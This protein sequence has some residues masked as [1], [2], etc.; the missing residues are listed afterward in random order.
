MVYFAASCNCS[1]IWNDKLMLIELCMFV[2]KPSITNLLKWRE[3]GAGC[4]VMHA[5]NWCYRAFFLHCNQH[6][7][8]GCP[9]HAIIIIFWMIIIWGLWFN[10]GWIECMLLYGRTLHF[11]T[12]I[13]KGP[14]LTAACGQWLQHLFVSDA[15][16]LCEK[17]F[18]IEKWS[19]IFT[20][21]NVKLSINCWT[22]TW[23]HCLYN[24]AQQLIWILTMSIVAPWMARV[25]SGM[26][27]YGNLMLT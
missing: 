10:K 9:Q 22:S 26:P 21:D 18:E 3:G 12:K 2:P 11:M 24:V 17:K 6:T 23:C 19:K 16:I 25:S 7:T 14:Y 8:D 4:H 5:T 27:L 13:L 1:T 20:Q 15:L